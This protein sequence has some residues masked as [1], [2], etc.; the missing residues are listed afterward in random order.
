MNHPTKCG[1][2]PFEVVVTRNPGG[3]S[4]CD[5][6]GGSFI[7]EGG[8]SCGS[9]FAL[10]SSLSLSNNGFTVTISSSPPQPLLKQQKA[11]NERTQGRYYYNCT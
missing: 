10:N 6:D 1:K 4:K 11:N 8:K 7:S 3:G 2:I 9:S 5:G